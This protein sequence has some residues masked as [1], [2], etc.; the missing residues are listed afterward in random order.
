MYTLFRLFEIFIG[1]ILKLKVS[2]FEVLEVK[3]STEGLAS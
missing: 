3:N 1:L 2:E